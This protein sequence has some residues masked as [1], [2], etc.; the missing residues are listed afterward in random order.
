M[1]KVY[2]VLSS[3]LISSGFAM[4]IYWATT[5]INK[6]TWSSE[7][8]VLV[9]IVWPIVTFFIFLFA[10]LRFHFEEGNNG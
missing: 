2:K 8:T 3:F 1:A 7:A 9:T 6:S 10:L 4:L 5:D